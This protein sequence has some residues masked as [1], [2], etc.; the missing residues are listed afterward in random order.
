M[1]VRTSSRDELVARFG[2]S[3]RSDLRPNEVTLHL[4]RDAGPVSSSRNRPIQFSRTDEKGGLAAVSGAEEPSG[5]R[6]PRQQSSLGG[7]TSLG[8][9]SSSADS[10][11]SIRFVG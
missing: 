9:L 7:V 1:K 8:R 2:F 6:F 11:S 10:V 5:I 3:P 4:F